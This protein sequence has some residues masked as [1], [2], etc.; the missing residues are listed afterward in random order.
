MTGVRG[1]AGAGFWSAAVA[2][3]AIIAVGVIGLGRHLGTGGALDVGLWVVAGNIIHDLAV[4]PL[5]G[6]IAIAASLVVRPP[7]RTPLLAGLA[8][9]AVVVLFAVPLLG[10]Y[11]A[12]P[13]NPSVLPLSYPSAVVTVLV[14]VWTAVALWCAA[15]AWQRRGRAGRFR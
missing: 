7:W 5:A 1:P 14:V 8:I 2:G 12:K 13:K 15:I 4:V 10:R 3:W 11:G 6:A 9:S